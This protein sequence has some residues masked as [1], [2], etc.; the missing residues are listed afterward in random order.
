MRV[1]PDDS[2]AD[3]AD[4]LHRHG[5]VVVGRGG[6]GKS[7][8][9][10]DVASARPGPW[11]RLDGRAAIK[12]EPWG[13]VEA[14]VDDDLL[15]ALDSGARSARR[16]LARRLTD[17]VSPAGVL[18]VDDAQWIHDDLLDV[19][20]RVV[21]RLDADTRVIVAHRPRLD[22]PILAQLDDVVADGRPPIILDALDEEEL[23]S[24][25]G[26]SPLAEL[27]QIAIDHLVTTTGGLPAMVD[28]LLRSAAD[29]PR[30][31]RAWLAGGSPTATVIETIRTAYARLTPTARRVLSA[32]SFGSSPAEDLL[33]MLDDLDRR[34]LAAALLV[35]D[36]A[37]LLAPGHTEPI[38]VVAEVVPHL[39]PSTE[40]TRHHLA[41]ATSLAHRSDAIVRRAEHL[42]AA[43]G[44]TPEASEAFLRACDHLLDG[45]PE[46]SVAWLDEARRAGAEAVEIA[47]RATV[48][49]T[50]LGRPLEAIRASA[51]LG[52]RALSPD[53]AFALAR[54]YTEAR[55]PL[56]AGGVWAALA[57]RPDGPAVAGLAAQLCRVV[58]GRIDA[59]CDLV[60][61][62]VAG[63]PRA[64]AE[65]EVARLIASAVGLLA[66]DDEAGALSAAS[67]ASSLE[68][69][70]LGEQRLPFSATSF[71]TWL[72][73]HLG[74]VG[75]AARIC[76]RSLSAR[77][78]SDAIR[79]SRVA[80][81]EFVNVVGGAS[82]TT[83]DLDG[84]AEMGP[85]DRLV[86]VATIAGAARRSNDLARLVELRPLLHEV[87]LSPPDLL[88][89][90]A[91]GEAL[92]SAARLGD[93][94]LVDAARLTRD[95][96]FV[97]LPR[98]SMV[99]ISAWQDLR[100]AAASD[101][102]D[103]AADVAR[104]LAEIDPGEGRLG[105]LV[106]V[107]TVWTA[108]LDGTA[109]VDD[110]TRA[111]RTLRELGFRWEATRL[112]GAA[113]MHIDDTDGA[114]ELLARA[115]E[116]RVDL[117]TTHDATTPL[118]ARLSERELEVAGHLTEG[119]TYKEIGG[120]LYISPK[121]V[122]HHVARIRQRLGA[123]SRAEM[124]EVL[125]AELPHPA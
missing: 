21:S 10:N 19:L 46:A 117:R 114:R 5:G 91:F 45:A 22:R 72:A 101:R 17:R 104:R 115:R 107:M 43:D 122:E 40:R 32:M 125:R 119:L 102:G 120:R 33:D 27:G 49:F 99:T 62:A 106:E 8:L 16:E 110:V 54:S 76:A 95:R 84:W 98:R 41:A 11:L 44:Q 15:D 58:A 66:D 61:T 79:R 20:T 4:A 34:D 93:H 94:D 65:E 69:A 2:G 105:R 88:T 86:T 87:L 59:G 56:Q 68:L 67:D 18:V 81:S 48:M 1:T 109:E 23:R 7:E 80:R 74:D 78:R 9:L 103:L 82:E 124:L 89:N 28:A 116:L 118:S 70:A 50:R 51:G 55:R 24:I 47:S 36:D 37:G 64:D 60:T 96:A 42:L 14:L 52:D 83:L 123:T 112:V 113:A 39:H 73:L 30:T 53:E 92:V 97:R 108:A 6:T 85:A 25:A 121:T 29:D 77:S 57:D 100:I 75:H 111:G 38:P 63:E 90:A 35:L 12:H 3:R 26:G 31:H 71:A 13:A